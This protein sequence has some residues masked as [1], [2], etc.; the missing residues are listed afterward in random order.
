MRVLSSTLVTSPVTEVRLAGPAAPDGGSLTV[1]GVGGR[2]Q[3][4]MATWY[5]PPWSGLTAA[6]PWLP[7]GTHVTV[8]DL[9]R[10]APLPWSSMTGD[11]SGQGVSST[12]RPRRSRSSPRSA[13][14]SSGSASTGSAAPGARGPAR[15][16]ALRSRSASTSCSTRT[17][18]DAIARDAGVCPGV[19]VVEIGAGLG[20][21]TV[22]A[23]QGRRRRGRSRSS[24]TGRSIP[25]LEEA[26][27]AI[28][29]GPR[30]RG[31]RHPHRLAGDARRRRV[32]PAAPTSRT[33]SGPGSCSTLIAASD[34]GSAIVVLLQREVGE[35][36]AAAPGDGG[37][38]PDEPAGRATRATARLVRDVPPEVFWPR[39][40]VGSVVVRLDRRPAPAGG[41]RRGRRC[42]ASSTAAF[43]QRRKTIRN[44]V[45]RL[46]FGA[47]D[48]AAS[49][50]A[51][52]GRRRRPAPKRC[53]W[54]P[55]PRSRRR[56]P[57]DRDRR[58]RAREA[59]RVPPRAR[60]PRRRRSRHPDRWS[61]RSSCTTCRRRRRPTPSRWRS[62]ATGRRSSRRRA[63]SRSWSAPPS[64]SPRRRGCP[65]ALRS[66]CGSTSASR[67]PPA[68]AAGAPTR[69]RCSGR[70]A[71]AR[72]HRRPSGWPASAP[73]SAPTSRALLAG[74]PV[75]AEGRG[76][77]VAPVHAHRDPLG[78]AAVRRRGPRRR[79]LRVV[80]RGPGHR[81]GPRRA[82]RRVRDGPSTWWPTPL[83]ND[84]AA[85]WSRRHP[86][87]RRR[88]R[89]LPARPARSRR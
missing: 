38:R 85:R 89:R 72:R 83:S 66:G 78:G 16:R 31:R 61:C 75:F 37:L 52:R 73:R 68:W 65:G 18:P 49:P 32:D 81:A 14:A 35:R 39:P 2:T 40:S 12:S 9:D 17:S 42:G 4:G 11:R 1:P 36:L 54:P 86:G 48:A 67:W 28:A 79:R 88:D 19:R 44:A 70:S 63:A 50:G 56:C 74:G 62:R 46:G 24:S 23:R 21:L 30:P 43:A 33:T 6:H 57:R 41:R 64:G 84:L 34:V 47:S 87:G 55:S 25:A 26:V 71:A 45:R 22:G 15:R 29:R 59:Q 5:D 60:P 69:R 58:A 10:G 7:K 13:E 3:A 76:E 77:R 27:D 51:R 82:R 80:G 20:S 8:T 53:R